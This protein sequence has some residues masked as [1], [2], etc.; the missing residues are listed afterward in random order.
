MWHEWHCIDAC[1]IQTRG[2]GVGIVWVVRCLRAES[3]DAAFSNRILLS[4]ARHTR[5]ARNLPGGNML[6]H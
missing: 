3:C 4:F 5:H 1:C 6:L 2:H